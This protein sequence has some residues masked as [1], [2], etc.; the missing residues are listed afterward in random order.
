MFD[1]NLT[2]ILEAIKT[3]HLLIIP[4]LNIVGAI[5][6]GQQVPA[7]YI[8]TILATVGAVLGFLFVQQSPGGVLVG[9]VMAGL[10]VGFHGGV[11]N[12]VENRP[13]DAKG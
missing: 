10:A 5:L 3:P 12:T 6:K 4:A 11:K 2:Q 7:K 8:P 13:P 1:L 9:F